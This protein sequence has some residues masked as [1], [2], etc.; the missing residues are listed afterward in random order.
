MKKGRREN[1]LVRERLENI[2]MNWS[3]KALSAAL[4]LFCVVALAACSPKVG[5]ERWCKKMEDKSAADWTARE[6]KDYAK[7]CVFD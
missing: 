1:K 2:Y 4:A 7:H 3:V 6:T 5:S